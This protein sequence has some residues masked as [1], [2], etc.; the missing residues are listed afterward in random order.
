[1][2]ID[3]GSTWRAGVVF[4]LAISL[5]MSHNTELGRLLSAATLHNA[6]ELRRIQQRDD[7]RPA[8][9]YPVVAAIVPAVAALTAALVVVLVRW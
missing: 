7:N 9:F 1:M 4:S 6:Q 5:G 3:Y 2:V 8:W